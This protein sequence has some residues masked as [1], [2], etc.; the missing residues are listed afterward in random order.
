MTMSREE[1]GG[2]IFEILVS[3]RFQDEL[4]PTRDDLMEALWPVLAQVWREGYWQGHDDGRGYTAVEL[5]DED[6]INPYDH[7]RVA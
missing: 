2:R 7:E 6:R 5:E 1:I 3:N 4:W